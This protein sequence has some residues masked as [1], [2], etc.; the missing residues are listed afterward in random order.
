MYVVYYILLILL[1]LSKITYNLKQFAAK[2]AV[3]EVPMQI[4]SATFAPR[5]LP[6]RLDSVLLLKFMHCSFTPVTHYKRLTL[7][8]P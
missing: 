6:G 1:I 2:R 5:L 8:N 7:F 4:F 3:L